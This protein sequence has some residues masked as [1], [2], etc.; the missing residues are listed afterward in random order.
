[1][2]YFLKIAKSALDS[3]SQNYYANTQK[4]TYKITMLSTKDALFTEDSTICLRKQIVTLLC[5]TEDILW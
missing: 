4:S 2:C 3:T 1:M 5:Y